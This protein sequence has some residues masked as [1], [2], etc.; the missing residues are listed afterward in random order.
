M[1]RFMML[2]CILT[3]SGYPLSVALKIKKESFHFRSSA[4]KSGTKG[5][6]AMFNLHEVRHNSALHVHC[7][8]LRCMSDRSDSSSICRMT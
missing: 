5:L 2:A 8:T 4:R 7:R 3:R 1:V 6:S